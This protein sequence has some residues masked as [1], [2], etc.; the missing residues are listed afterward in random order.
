MVGLFPAMESANTGRIVRKKLIKSTMEI[1]GF[2]W[3]FVARYI[4]MNKHIIGDLEKI[5]K[6]I[7]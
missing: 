1:D 3:K 7:P 4:A 2:P 5:K 6:F